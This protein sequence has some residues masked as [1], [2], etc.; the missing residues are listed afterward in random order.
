MSDFT[1]SKKMAERLIESTRRLQKMA[2]EVGHAKQVKDFIGDM[3]KNLLAKYVVR[4]LKAGK[5]AVAA[6]AHGRA[7]PEF[8]RE[9][10]ALATQDG[11]AETVIAS[12]QAE[13]SA[14]DA[15][16]SLLSLQKSMYHE[17]QG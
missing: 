13:Q 10:E 1:D 7:D 16:R 3:R 17:L 6:E 14:F 2:V 9:L 4:A 15:A 8:Q 12:W 11:A 5:T